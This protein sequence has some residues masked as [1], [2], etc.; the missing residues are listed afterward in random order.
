MTDQP[1]NP[2][3]GILIILFIIIFVSFI[4]LAYGE[5]EIDTIITNEL[6]IVSGFFDEAHVGVALKQ[7][8]MLLDTIR[9]ETEFGRYH[10]EIPL[11]AKEGYYEL[12]V[13]SASNNQ[14]VKIFIG[15]QPQVEEIAIDTPYG[16]EVAPATIETAELEALVDNGIP[17]W[18]KEVFVMWA[19]GYISDLELIASLEYL[20]KTG[21]IQL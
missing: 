20:I 4:S 1:L 17:E 9:G 18:V 11:P 10:V 7:N 15:I 13:G 5:L 6:I 14:S 2:I 21:I 8:G 19:D 16:G 12:L 3:S